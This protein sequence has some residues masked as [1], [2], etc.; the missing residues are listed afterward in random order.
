LAKL[1]RGDITQAVTLEDDG[2][3]CGIPCGA[4]SDGSGA[5]D[6]P[7]ILVLVLLIIVVILEERCVRIGLRFEVFKTFRNILIA[8]HEEFREV[9]SQ[10]QLEDKMS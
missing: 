1:G 8:F 2:C 10:S 7:G 5:G 4:L 3:V 6:G 9:T